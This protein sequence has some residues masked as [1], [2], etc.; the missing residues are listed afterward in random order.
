V[1]PTAKLNGDAFA[2]AMELN[3]SAGVVGVVVVIIGVVFVVDVDADEQAPENTVRVANN[4]MVKQYPI[5]RNCFLFTLILHFL[6][7][8]ISKRSISLSNTSRVEITRIII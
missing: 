5:N 7:P 4:P 3:I 8:T 6:Y 2:M 1:A